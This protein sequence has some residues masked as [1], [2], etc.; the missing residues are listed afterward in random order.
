MIE[1][2]VV[3]GTPCVVAGYLPLDARRGSPHERR[4]VVNAHDPAY[5]LDVDYEVPGCCVE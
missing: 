5:K 1:R 4:L 2:M 3:G